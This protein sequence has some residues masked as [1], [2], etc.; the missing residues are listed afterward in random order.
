LLRRRAET[1]REFFP[2]IAVDLISCRST[3]QCQAKSRK[4]F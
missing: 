3:S 2:P 4:A 1:P